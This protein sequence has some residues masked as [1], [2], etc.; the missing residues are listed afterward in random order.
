M[1]D[2]QTLQVC[3]QLC[4]NKVETLQREIHQMRESRVD[5][6]FLVHFSFYV[7]L[8]FSQYPCTDD[9]KKT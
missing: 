1:T 3:Y 4:K 2:R 9:K 5:E 7:S 8:F 6:Q